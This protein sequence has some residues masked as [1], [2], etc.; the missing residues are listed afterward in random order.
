MPQVRLGPHSGRYNSQ[1]KCPCPKQ[2]TL[3]T[4][5]I[6]VKGNIN[7]THGGLCPMNLFPQLSCLVTSVHTIQII[8]TLSNNKYSH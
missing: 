6:W 4:D 7:L 1:Y 3:K 8:V 2:L 5:K